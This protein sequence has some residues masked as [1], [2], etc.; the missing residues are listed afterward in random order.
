V[1]ISRFTQAEWNE[2]R[3]MQAFV[4]RL[5]KVSDDVSRRA[6]DYLDHLE[7]RLD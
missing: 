3:D 5:V 4:A 2:I 6:K 7:G 1:T